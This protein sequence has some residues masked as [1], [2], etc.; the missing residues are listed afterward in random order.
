ME[1]PGSLC[2]ALHV[3]LGL[4]DLAMPV[5]VAGWYAPPEQLLLGYLSLAA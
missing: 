5:L 4:L 1:Q 3:F 2:P